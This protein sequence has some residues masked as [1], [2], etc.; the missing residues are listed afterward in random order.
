MSPEAVT[1]DAAPPISRRHVA[2][3]VVGNWLEF[4][5]FIVF[6]LFAVQIGAAFSPEP[7]GIR[8]A[9]AVADHLRRR[10]RVPAAGGGGHRA[11]RRPGGAQARHAGLIRDD[12][13]GDPGPGLRAVLRPDRGGG[14]G[15]GRGLPPGPGLRPRRRGRTDHR[16]SG[17]GR[18]ART[19]RPYDF[20][21]ERQPIDRRPVGRRP[22]LHSRPYL[23]PPRLRRLR[24]ADR[25]RDRRPGAAVR[26]RDSKR[27]PET[28]GRA[29]PRLG[30]PPAP[31]D[32]PRSLAHPALGHGPGSPAAPSRPTSSSS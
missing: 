26:L 5:D 20:L 12:G 27:L 32:D 29:E 17:G 10:L 28:L 9:D 23:E 15:A 11:V 7:V 14:A 21:A 31:A 16:L 25:L 24:L 6:A 30:G 4:Y 19:P 18:A 8:P 13:G 22:G 2:A 3:A 1:A